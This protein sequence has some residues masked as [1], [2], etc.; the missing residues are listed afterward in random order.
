MPSSTRRTFLGAC[1][2]AWLAL[3]SWFRAPAPAAEDDG[4]VVVN[5]WILKRSDLGAVAD[6]R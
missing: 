3:P 4:F 6:D 1:A 5:G 2:A